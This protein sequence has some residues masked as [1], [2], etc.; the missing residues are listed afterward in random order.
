LRA[1]A[2]VGNPER[3]ELPS[4]QQTPP[5]IKEGDFTVSSGLGQRFRRVIR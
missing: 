5:D 1:I 3:L 4:L 2:A